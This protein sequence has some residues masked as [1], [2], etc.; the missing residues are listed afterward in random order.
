MYAKDASWLYTVGV[1]G[2]LLQ[3]ATGPDWCKK[4]SGGI[5]LSAACVFALRQVKEHIRVDGFLDLD[6][7]LLLFYHHAISYFFVL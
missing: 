6:L 3:Q 2:F 4:D 5:S 1:S 7:L